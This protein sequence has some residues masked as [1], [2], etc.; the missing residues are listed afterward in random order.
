MCFHQFSLNIQQPDRP[1][2]VFH[3][4][5]GDY[6]KLTDGACEDR[7]KRGSTLYCGR[8][9]PNNFTS[10]G[11]AICLTFRSDASGNGEGFKL[12]Y[13]ANQLAPEK[14][15]VRGMGFVVHHS[16]IFIR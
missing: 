6:L 1:D 5:G 15:T 13:S 12:Q 2:P 4:C 11:N 14:K 3:N 9:I 7:S 10:T 8:G 16:S